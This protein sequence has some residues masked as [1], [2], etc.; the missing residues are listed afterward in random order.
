MG[1]LAF[2]AIATFARA[3]STD[4]VLVI[5]QVSASGGSPARIVD[6]LGSWG[7]D[8]ALQLDY[9]L[10]V[11]VSQGSSYVR[12]RFGEQPVS[13]TFADLADGLS[14]GEIAALEATGSPEPAASI[15]RLALHEMTLSLPAI[16]APG[17]L[18]V[19]V[20]VSLPGEGT[21]LSNSAQSSPAL[22]G[23]A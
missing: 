10:S 2:L 17:D 9:P 6:L 19:V 12:Y 8:D 4:P 15:T 5:G 13:G 3:G 1:V 16:F 7:F 23:G 20:Y 11:V 18:S 22:E 21:F 14:V